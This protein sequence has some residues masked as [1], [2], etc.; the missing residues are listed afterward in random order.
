[1]T[2]PRSTDA[3]VRV[4]VNI[5]SHA[6]ETNFYKSVAGRDREVFQHLFYL[7]ALIM[8]GQ[9]EQQKSPIPQRTVTD[10]N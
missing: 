2:K 1:M 6:T 9:V 5:N 3:T 4:W 8:P 10:S 7:S